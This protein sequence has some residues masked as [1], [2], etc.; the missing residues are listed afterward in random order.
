MSQHT[1]Q[2]KIHTSLIAFLSD[3]FTR[4]FQIFLFWGNGVGS[5]VSP[6]PFWFFLELKWRLG[7]TNSYLSSSLRTQCHSTV[8]LVPRKTEH[9]CALISLFP[10]TM[11]KTR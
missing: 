6:A 2:E 1:F 4:S 9:C 8:P 7:G 3:V 11:A 10:L 5:L